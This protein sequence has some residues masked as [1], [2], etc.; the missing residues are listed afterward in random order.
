MDSN[1]E[2]QTYIKNR[3]AVQEYGERQKLYT[4]YIRTND[5]EVKRETN[6]SSTSGVSLVNKSKHQLVVMV[7]VDTYTF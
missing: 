4:Q 7:Q 3:E 2:I 1:E 6:P 5:E